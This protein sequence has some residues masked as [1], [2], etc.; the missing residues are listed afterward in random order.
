MFSF[1]INC[2]SSTWFSSIV[3]LKQDSPLS[4]ILFI[5][6]S[7]ML[8]KALQILAT[9]GDLQ[10]F[11]PKPHG[12]CIMHLMYADDLILVPKATVNNAMVLRTTIQNYCLQSCQRVNMHKS[13]VQFS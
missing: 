12:L 10:G 2:Q 9:N 1:I 5:L 11:L 7:D 8:S 3:G 13:H 6:F 4:P